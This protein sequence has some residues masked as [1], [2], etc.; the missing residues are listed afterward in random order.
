MK[1]LNSREI[2]VKYLDSLETKQRINDTK[3]ALLRYFVPSVG[4]PA[5]SA[6]KR[7]PMTPEEA[8]A[9]FEFLKQISLEELAN[10]PDWALKTLEE[11]DVT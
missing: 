11:R 10:A 3:N 2:C 7:R 6:A 9:G 1:N 8:K 5:V 4:G